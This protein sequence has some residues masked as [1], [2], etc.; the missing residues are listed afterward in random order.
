M[1]AAWAVDRLGRSLVDLLGLLG[2]LHAKLDRG[3]LCSR[4]SLFEQARKL[5]EPQQIP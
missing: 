3:E 1:V 2:E 4:E 5:T